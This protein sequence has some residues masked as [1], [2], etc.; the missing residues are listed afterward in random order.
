[1]DEI[2]RRLALLADEVEAVTRPPGAASAIRR[3]RGRRAAGTAAMLALVVVVAGTVARV[4]QEGAGPV[5]VP[6]PTS[7]PPPIPRPTAGLT[8]AVSPEPVVLGRLV[9]IAGA[10][11]A[12]GSVAAVSLDGLDREPVVLEPPVGDDGR[13]SIPL[14][15]PARVGA[16]P[17][18][19]RV[20]VY[21]DD[22]AGH[23]QSLAREVAVVAS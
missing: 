23:P 9:R 3:S 10:G 21:C 5:V 13:F 4:Q 8:V 11:C 6:Q 14:T 19:L 18:N 2:K 7:A 20:E 22:P 17:P 15:L 16:P 12:P 1:M